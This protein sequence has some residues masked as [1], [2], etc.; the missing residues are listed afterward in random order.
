[1]T[2]ISR[3]TNLLEGSAQTVTIASSGTTSGAIFVGDFNAGS[4]LLPATMTGTAMT[5]HGSVDGV[6]WVAIRND[7]GTALSAV[8]TAANGQYKIPA[9]AFAYQSIKFVSG[10]TE[11]AERTITVFLKG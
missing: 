5:I 7:A 3:Q 8:T 10:S 2:A 6:T 4:Y 11:A 9:E 1:M